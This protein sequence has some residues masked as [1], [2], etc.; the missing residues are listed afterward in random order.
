MRPASESGRLAALGWT[1]EAAVPTLEIS[2]LTSRRFPGGRSGETGR[3]DAPARGDSLTPV[4]EPGRGPGSRD[5]TTHKSDSARRRWPVG[6]IPDLPNRFEAGPLRSS[7]AESFLCR[8]AA[9]RASRPLPHVP[10]PPGASV[11]SGIA[12]LALLPPFHYRADC[13]AGRW[14]LS[15]TTRQKSCDGSYRLGLWK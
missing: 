13:I 4:G 14:R 7:R 6:A 15:V 2:V 8:C 5:R 12:P 9:E 1:A 10:C 3:P 11:R